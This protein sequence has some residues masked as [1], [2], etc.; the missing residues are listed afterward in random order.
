M[1]RLCNCATCVLTFLMTEWLAAATTSVRLSVQLSHCLRQ[2]L[3]NDVVEW[4]AEQYRQH[5]CVVV[6]WTVPPRT[7]VSAC[8]YVMSPA[9]RTHRVIRRLRPRPHQQQCPSNIRHC[10][11]NRSTCSIRQCCFAVTGPRLWN[12]LLISLR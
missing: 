9:R 8:L 4:N 11:K 12:S 5:G 6:N 1:A 10:R 7:H 2:Q 3:T